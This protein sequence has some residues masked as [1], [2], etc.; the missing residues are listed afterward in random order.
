[1]GRIS[2]ASSPKVLSVRVSASERGLL[3]SAAER[4]R[5]TVSEFIRRKALEAAELELLDRNLVVIPAADWERF[6][7]WANT[8][9]KAIDALRELKNHRPAWQD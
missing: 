4:G 1:M 3:A 9:A 8:P 5:T 7:A 2:N 6:E